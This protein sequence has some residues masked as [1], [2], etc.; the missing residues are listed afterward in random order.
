MERS[1]R[2]SMTA[3][4]TSSAK[5][6]P[7]F[8]LVKDQSTWA[9]WSDV[10]SLELERAG[11]KDPNGVGAIRRIRGSNGMEIREEITEVLEGQRI[12]YR[13]LS[14]LPVTFY[15]G[16]TEFTPA[17]NG[18][19]IVRWTSVFE[20]ESPELMRDLSFF[21]G[22]VVRKMVRQVSLAAEVSALRHRPIRVPPKPLV[23]GT[24]AVAHDLPRY[25]R[26]Y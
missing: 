18:G 26:L 11:K 8:D 6:Q 25:Q 17:S 12:R 15:E 14:G 5:L 20:P 2:T 23:A 4:W 19:T 3:A 9:D 10:Q 13:L 21:V 22:R 1:A 7:L 16:L 24:Q